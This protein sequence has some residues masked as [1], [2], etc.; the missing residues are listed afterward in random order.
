MP[1]TIPT[2]SRPLK[3]SIVSDDYQIVQPREVLEFYR[4]LM[5]LYGYTLETAGALDSGR[6]VWALAKTG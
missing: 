5:E 1:I 6:K 4:E 2:G 3:L